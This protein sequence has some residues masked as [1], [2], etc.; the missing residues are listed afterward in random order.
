MD[1]P[2]RSLCTKFIIYAIILYGDQI[3]RRSFFMAPYFVMNANKW[4]RGGQKLFFNLLL[5]LSGFGLNRKYIVPQPRNI[6]NFFMYF[7]I[8]SCVFQSKNDINITQTFYSNNEKNQFF[9]NTPSRYLIIT[10]RKQENKKNKI[11]RSKEL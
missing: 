5:F 8:I 9:I 2:Y 3:V 7:F 4:A 10:L 1:S 6:F 11:Q